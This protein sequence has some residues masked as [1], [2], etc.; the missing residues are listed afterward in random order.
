MHHAVRINSPALLGIQEIFAVRILLFESRMP[1]VRKECGSLRAVR[2]I[3]AV[4][5]CNRSNLFFERFGIVQL[6]QE[7]AVLLIHDIARVVPRRLSVL[8][9]VVKNEV[10]NNRDRHTAFDLRKEQMLI[11][12]R[13]I[14]VMIEVVVVA[15]E[16]GVEFRIRIYCVVGETA[17]DSFNILAFFILIVY[18]S[19]CKCLT[20]SCVK[21]ARRDEEGIVGIVE[22]IV[23]IDKL[24]HL[25]LVWVCKFNRVYDRFKLVNVCLSFSHIA[26][27]AFDIAL[28]R[29]VHIAVKLL[30]N[31]FVV[32]AQND[33]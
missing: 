10:H 19:K 1:F 15:V 24:V 20:L 5:S 11:V 8:I 27:F 29:A 16:Y 3:N 32:I 30:G 22:N 28:A 14:T 18:D 23:L 13:Q 25:I 31:R 6:I 26:L 2:Q 17:F 33:A 4:C 21:C 7:V 9:D 12:K